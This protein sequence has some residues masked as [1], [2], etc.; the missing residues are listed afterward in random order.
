MIADGPSI[1]LL[2]RLDL[3]NEFFWT[4]GADGR[5]RFLRCRAC[6]SLVHPPAPRCPYCL[7]GY[8]SPEP[9]SG[10]GILE[11][12]TVN[13]QQWIPGSER[14]IVG[15]VSMIEQSDVR[16]TTNIVGADPKD[17]KIGMEVEVVFEHQDDVYLPLFRPVERSAK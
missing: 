1:R 6:E 8:L 11:S 4:S 7:A 12:F 9:V 2:P 13:H 16:L 17:V 15:L 3:D 5:L 10:R 14:Y